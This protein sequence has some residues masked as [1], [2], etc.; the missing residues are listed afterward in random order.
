MK[1]I[2]TLNALL[3]IFALFVS[4]LCFAAKA[5][6]QEIYTAN[7]KSLARH[8]AVPDWFRDAKLGI[9]FTW[10]PIQ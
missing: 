9:Y 6:A 7:E 4:M 3:A 8:Y 5:Q 10:A 2:G 1:K